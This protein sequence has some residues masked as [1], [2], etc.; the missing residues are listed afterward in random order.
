M[1]TRGAD[2]R[3]EYT[4]EVGEVVVLR[5]AHVCGSERFAVTLVGV[6]VRLSCAGCGRRVIVGRDRL[7]ARVV[8]VAGRVEPPATW[9]DG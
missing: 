7:S 9:E 2:G 3:S 6:D 8:D 1:L 5:R 4:P